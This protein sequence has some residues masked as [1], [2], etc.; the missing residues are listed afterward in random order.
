MGGCVNFPLSTEAK[1]NK[2]MTTA[3]RFF[4]SFTELP[5]ES[6]HDAIGFFESIALSGLEGKFIRLSANLQRK[7]FGC[8][9]FGR[10]GVK[11]EGGTCTTIKAM[12]YGRDFDTQ[13]AYWSMADRKWVS[14]YDQRVMESFPRA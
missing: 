10:L 6:K 3:F 11:V 1:P 9:P 14:P 7:F 12:D 2:N 5:L 4:P 13:S 8:V